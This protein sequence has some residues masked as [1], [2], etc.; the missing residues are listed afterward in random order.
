MEIKDIA[1]YQ[2]EELTIDA[3]KVQVQALLFFI[4]FA[5]LFGIP[6]FLVWSEKLTEESLSATF[7]NG[8][9]RLGLLLL[10]YFGGI[11]VHE[12]I[13]GATWSLFAKSGFRSIRFGVLWKSLTPYCHC[14]EPLLMKHYLIGAIMPGIVLGVVPLVYALISGSLGWLTFGLFFSM[15][16]GGDFMLIKLIWSQNF[17]AL[18]HDHPSKIGCVVYKPIK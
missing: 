12:L 9:W 13:H 5:L 14:N 10:A 3:V 15:A 18:I 6:Y 2:Q 4:P 7:S 17:N 11:I 1:G 16:A 8:F